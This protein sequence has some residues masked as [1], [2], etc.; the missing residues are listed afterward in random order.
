MAGCDL[1]FP[2]S[3]AEDVLMFDTT[4][5]DGIDPPTEKQ[6]MPAC[7]PLVSFP[8]DER[9][10]MRYE[11]PTG[12]VFTFSQ[13]KWDEAPTV[14]AENVPGLPGAHDYYA[15]AFLDCAAAGDKFTIGPD[16]ND[17]APFVID[18]SEVKAIASMVH[19]HT[20]RAKGHFETTWVGSDPSLPF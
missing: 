2:R 20:D 11:T 10:T 18:A 17:Q 4:A 3:Q 9:A 7:L 15:S 13:K 12:I 6:D 16:F 8:G 5:R 14:I 19:E 1:D